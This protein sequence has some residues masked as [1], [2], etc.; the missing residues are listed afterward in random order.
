MKKNKPFGRYSVFTFT[1]LAVAIPLVSGCKP[2]E[3]VHT[4]ATYSQAMPVTIDVISLSSIERSHEV[5]AQAQGSKEV[6]IRARV[7]GIL[8]DQVVADG[9]RVKAG[10]VLFRIDREPL[11]LAVEQARAQA[12][13]AVAKTKQAMREENRM[14]M[15]F[16]GKSVSRKDYDDAVSS[17][18]MAQASQAA[19]K[20]ALKTAELNLSYASVTSPIDGV[21]SSH[22]KSIGSL[23]TTGSDSLLTSVVQMDPVWVNFSLTQQEMA[24]MGIDHIG[25][26]GINSVEAQLPDGSIYPVEG[27]IVFVDSKIDPSLSTIQMRAEFPNP[28]HTIIP[29]QFLRLKLKAG[30]YEHAVLIPQSAVV[31][32]DK[33]NIVYTVDQDN[34]VSITPIQTGSWNGSEWLVLS[35]LKDGD[36]VVLDNIVKLHPGVAVSASDKKQ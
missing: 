17:R 36:R 18:E 22:Q 28:D 14:Q 35:G 25:V 9:S 33:G 13:E 6:E 27:K 8:E 1:V 24:A 31:Q 21:M 32:S 12:M 11:K 4:A 19:A 29:G 3:P 23:I 10:Q 20:A 26:A 30:N 7:G 15:A 16:A 5:V 2:N 34:K